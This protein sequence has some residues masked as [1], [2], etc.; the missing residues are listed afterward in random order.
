MINYALLDEKRAVF[1]ALSAVL[2]YP[3]KRFINDR[4]L[5]LE[6]FKNPKT[7]D[8]ITAFWEEISTLTFGQITETYVD[9]FDFNKKNNALHD[10][11]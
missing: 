6:T 5:L 9:T 8:L 2:S 4:F 7:L 3:E 11:L 10:F 1:G